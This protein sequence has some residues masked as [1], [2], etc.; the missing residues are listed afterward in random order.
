MLSSH[1]QR[2]LRCA[3]NY[4][5]SSVDGIVF[6][7]TLA[8]AAFDAFKELSERKSKVQLIVSYKQ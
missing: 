8:A 1:M 6:S 3:R 5:V 7:F 4:D 2:L